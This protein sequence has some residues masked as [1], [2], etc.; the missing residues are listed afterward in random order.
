MF[1][2]FSILLHPEEVHPV[3]FCGPCQVWSLSMD[4]EDKPYAL[5][6]LPGMALVWMYST[7][8]LFFYKISVY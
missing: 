4:V 6:P 8:S 1:Y 3:G 2:L 7:N 5:K